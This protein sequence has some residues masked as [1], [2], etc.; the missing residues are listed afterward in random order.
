M[1]IKDANTSSGASKDAIG[2]IRDVIPTGSFVA[3][4]YLGG[5]FACGR[6]H[7]IYGT[8]GAGKSTIAY[9][10][11]RETQRKGGWVFWLAAEAGSWD[12]QRAVK[13]GVDPKRVT[14]AYP[15]HLE[16]MMQWIF[17]LVKEIGP[18]YEKETGAPITV[19]V[20]SVNAS[21]LKSLVDTE[22]PFAQGMA[23]R[24][25]IIG[26][27]C[28][29]LE[30]PLAKTRICIL[31][32]NQIS[33]DLK[34]TMYTSGPGVKSAGTGNQLFHHVSTS[35]FLGWKTKTPTG[36]H[37]KWWTQKVR[38]ERPGAKWETYMWFYYG[39]IEWYEVFEYALANGLLL[40][41]GA[42]WTS[43]I[44]LQGIPGPKFQGSEGFYEKVEAH[45]AW[46][47]V[48]G[49]RAKYTVLRA[50]RG[51]D[52]KIIEA[53]DEQLKALN[54]ETVR[55]FKPAEGSQPLDMEA[56]AKKYRTM[57]FTILNEDAA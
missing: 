35:I 44:V 24:Q 8:Q 32:L 10:C 13:F 11:A 46:Y 22:N 19:V 29:L 38:S 15:E 21:P 5:G 23:S 25:R 3:D 9:Q 47:A 53:C 52:K 17:K 28:K 6:A 36:H 43:D 31:F 7:E 18:A 4:A 26:D 34:A 27:F 41:G 56:V 40:K 42:G 51:A 55:L 16:A 33:A 2:K 57:L 30:I 20:D 49:W 1:G 39:V 14:L 54:E 12:T 37:I 50:V 45:P 48:L